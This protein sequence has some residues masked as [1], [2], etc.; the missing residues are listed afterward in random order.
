MIRLFKRRSPAHRATQP[1]VSLADLFILR[2]F[3]Y[4]PAEWTALPNEVC[5]AK[6][7]EYFQAKGLGA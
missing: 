5:A 2:W 7:S 6:R 1:D 4:T 3:G